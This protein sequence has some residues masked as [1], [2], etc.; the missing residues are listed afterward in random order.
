MSSNI[1]IEIITYLNIT[2]LSEKQYTWFIL[3]C[4]ATYA[5]NIVL[6]LDI[7]SLVVDTVICSQHFS[8][9]LK[10]QALSLM[11]F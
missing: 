6:K 4:C 5:K 1:V 2:G 9:S 3:Q 8:I 10:S 7:P 11:L